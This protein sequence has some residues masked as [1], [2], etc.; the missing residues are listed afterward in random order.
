MVL[1]LKGLWEVEVRG[2]SPTVWAGVGLRNV[3]LSC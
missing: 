1:R 2:M 3:E